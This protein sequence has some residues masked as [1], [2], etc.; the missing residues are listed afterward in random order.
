VAQHYPVGESF[1]HY[2]WQFQY[3][4]KG[5]LKTTAG[6]TLNIIKPGILN[7]DAGPD[8]AQA[9]IKIDSIDWVGNAEIHV[10][11]SEWYDHKH[12]RDSAY[13]NV[14]LH[15]V[16]EDNRPV[17]RKDGSQIPTL[18]LKDRIDAQL[19]KSY[20]TLINSSLTIPCERYFIDVDVLLKHAMIDSALM[21]R[22]ETKSKLIKER[23]DYNKGDWEETT[24]QLLAE[25]FGFK[26]N[27]DPFAQ[28]AK[29]LSYKVL[30]KHRKQPIQVEALL[31]GQ[32]GFLVAKTKDEYLTQLYNEYQFLAKKYELSSEQLNVS[33]WKFLRLRP[34]NFPTIRLAQFAS[35][36][37]AHQSIFSTLIELSNY[38]TLV[39]FFEIH[40]SAYWQSHY[41]FGKKSKSTVAGLGQTSVENIII[42]TIV[43]LLVAY[44]QSKDDDSLVDRALNILQAVPSEKNRITRLWQSLGYTSKNAF[45]SQGLIELYN[46]FCQKRACMNCVIGSSLLKPNQPLK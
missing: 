12:D 5:A 30:H 45:D 26:V 10:K 20:Q 28:V 15:I 31:F 11:A 34:A 43:P 39:N 21:R 41:R 35:L 27:K 4:Q 33:Q 42:N 2:I 19:I 25:N 36:V 1:L 7:S 23:L 37:S 46:N 18:E 8:F 44:G 32:A 22:L 40:Q 6:E 24:Y 13:E 38:K 29:S 16:W 3:F 17:Y 9:K 14:V